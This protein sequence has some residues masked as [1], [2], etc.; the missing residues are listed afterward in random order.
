[1]KRVIVLVLVAAAVGCGD[2]DTYLGRE[3]DQPV[4]DGGVTHVKVANCQRYGV[5]EMDRAC[6]VDA[7]GRTQ[8]FGGETLDI[9]PAAAPVGVYF[10]FTRGYAPVAAD[11]TTAGDA[12][13]I[14][15]YA[16]PYNVTSPTACCPEADPANRI[17]VIASLTEEGGLLVTVPEQLPSGTQVVIGLWYPE[18]YRSRISPP[19]G[20]TCNLPGPFCAETSNRGWAARFYVGGVPE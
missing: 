5:E 3:L 4:P 13:A 8:G 12:P 7:D 1:M 11:L 14:A 19:D 17:D 10:L 15:A 9:V 2:H 16:G 18:L 6:V 20:S